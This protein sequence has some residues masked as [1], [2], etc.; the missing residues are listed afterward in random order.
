MHWSFALVNNRLAEIFFETSK[1]SK[2]FAHCYI[3]RSEYKTK[4]EKDWIAEDTKR[5]RFVYRK[6]RYQRIKI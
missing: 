4:K 3:K 6:G 1:K 2:I 5:T